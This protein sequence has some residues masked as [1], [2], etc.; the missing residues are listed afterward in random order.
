MIFFFVVVVVVA[1]LSLVSVLDVGFPRFLGRDLP[2][3]G[4]VIVVS[5]KCLVFAIFCAAIST[6][7]CEGREWV[8]WSRLYCQNI[9]LLE[10]SC[11]QRIS[12]VIG[13]WMSFVMLWKLL[14]GEQTYPRAPS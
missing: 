10:F 13:L 14:I 5:P 4:T 1:V 11:N 6:R 12:V 3:D 2:A 8:F 9:L 7:A